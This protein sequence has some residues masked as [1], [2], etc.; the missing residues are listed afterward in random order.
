MSSLKNPSSL[1]ELDFGHP[2]AEHDS[3]ALQHSFYEAESWKTISSDR[4]MPFV[5]GRKGSGKSA[6][7]ARLEIIAEKQGNCCFVRIVPA[8]FRHVEIR[9]LLGCLVNKNASWQYIYRKVWEGIILGQIVRHSI[10]C[11]KT[12]KSTRFSPELTHEMERFQM[13]C[14]F[15]VAA[16]GDALS[17]VITRHV[18][19]AS[20]KTDALSQVELRKMLQPYAW[21]TF[22]DVL[23]REFN[24]RALGSTTMFI[25]IDGLDEHWDASAPSLFFLAELLAVAKEFTARFGSAIRFLICLRD[26]I[27]RALVDTKSIE[28]DKIESLVINLEWNSRSL[29]ELIARRVAPTKKLDSAVAE[30]RNL[31]PE[32]VEGIAVEEYLARHIL[33]RPRDYVNFFRMLQKECRPEPRAG[34]GHI[35]DAVG[36]YCANRLMDL[37]NEFGFTYPH[38]TK[39]ITALHSL[40]DRFP[41]QELLEKLGDLCLLPSFRVEAPELMASYGQPLVLARI[42]VSIGAVG[43]YDPQSHALRFVHEFSESRVSALWES[44]EILGVHPVYCYKRGK[45]QPAFTIEPHA[46]IAAAILTHPPDYLP[47]KDAPHADLERYELQIRRKRDDLIAALTAIDRGQP[48]FRRFETWVK[49]TVALCYIGDLLNEEEQIATVGGNKRFE[50]IFDIVGGDPPWTEIKEKYRTH[51]LLVECKNTDEPTDADFTKLV[52]DMQSLD[53]HVAFMAYRGCRREPQ[54]KVLEHLRSAFINSNRE[55]IIVALSESFLIQCLGRNTV[56]KCRGNLNALWR[57]HVE[58]WLTT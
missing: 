35:M 22:E 6:I 40:P 43:V 25:A 49:K 16:L 33:Q 37:E 32:S 2:E 14:G 51:R 18:R 34:E 38:I 20:K 8:S 10:E 48:H 28:Y 23:Q 45:A 52:R 53:V 39:C 44:A 30:L 9:D 27:F 3:L 26:N 29:F 47:E 7:A 24:V 5:V 55:S 4:G 42:L 41:K 54:G 19:D 11:E 56:A 58:R 15:Y 50:I 13:E 46:E 57:D 12:H 31:L 1:S 21:T 36:K 17:D